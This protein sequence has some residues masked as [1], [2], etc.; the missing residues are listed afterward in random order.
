G[1]ADFLI[2][3]GSDSRGHRG[4][5]QRRHF[6]LQGIQGGPWGG[7]WEIIEVGERKIR[8][9]CPISHKEIEK[10]RFF[11]FMEERDQE[12]WPHGH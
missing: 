1:A 4:Q 12:P 7:D 6:F 9:K 10:D 11:F 2:V 5:V 8:L 3:T